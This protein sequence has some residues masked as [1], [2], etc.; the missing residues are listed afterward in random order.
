[1]PQCE[2]KYWRSQMQSEYPCIIAILVLLKAVLG[3]CTSLVTQ[4]L[5]IEFLT[6]A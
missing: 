3:V 2:K 1:M 6:Q 4:S 5:N